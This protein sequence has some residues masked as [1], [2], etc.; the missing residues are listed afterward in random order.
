MQYNT[1]PS[2]LFEIQNCSGNPP[3]LPIPTVDLRAASKARAQKRKFYYQK[4]ATRKN[5][6][7]LEF[8]NQIYMAN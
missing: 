5:P 4:L 1:M 6:L 7:I 8:S 2:Y 3:S